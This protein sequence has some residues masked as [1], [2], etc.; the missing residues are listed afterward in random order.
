MNLTISLLLGAL[1]GTGLAISGMTDTAKVLNFLD[2]TGDWDASLGFVMGAG[3]LVTIPAFYLI[4][5]Q[6]KPVL[7]DRFIRRRRRSN[8]L[9]DFNLHPIRLFQMRRRLHQVAVSI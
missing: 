7:G 4:Q 9:F 6:R 2:L 8:D 1:F 3:L 5:K